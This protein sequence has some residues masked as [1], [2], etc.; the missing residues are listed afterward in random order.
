MSEAE[1][2]VDPTPG[3]R[4]SGEGVGRLS[5]V[6][7]LQGGRGDILKR[8]ADP[9]ASVIAAME[10]LKPSVS[11]ASALA[12]AEGFGAGITDTLS[13]MSQLNAGY[14]ANAVGVAARGTPSLTAATLAGSVQ[15]TILARVAMTHD[16]W[17]TSASTNAIWESA[18]SGAL[19]GKSWPAPRSRRKPVDFFG[20][21]EVEV[22]SVRQLLRA[23]SALQQ[24]NSGLGLVWRGQRNAAW[25]VDS[26][27]TRALRDA[28]YQLDE[29]RLIAVE[30]FQLTAADRW[31]IARPDGDLAFFA[32]LQH[33]GAPT[34][35][36]D[37]SLD[38]EIGVWFAVSPSRDKHDD[39]DGRLIA[40]GRSPAPRR[41]RPAIPQ[42]FLLP[43]GNEAFWHSWADPG[44]R[45]ENEW[46]TGR[47][48]PAWQPPALNR[49]MRAQR[50][51]FLFDSE[52][53]I[54]KD[55]LTMFEESL[56]E[57]WRA[58][59]IAQSTR[60][61]GIPSR[62]DLKAK[63]NPNEIVPMFS[64]R[65]AARAKPEILDYL[66]TKGLSENTIYPDKAGFVAY[67]RR[68]SAAESM[69]ED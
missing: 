31:G 14:L 67:L 18:L 35:L 65:I 20:S 13:V 61:L 30:K 10:A 52:P 25:A 34:R 26:S 49:R 36:I 4:A 57:S 46:G 58:K 7:G 45:R 68:V 33:Q 28:K 47:S 17:G 41:N 15:D 21:F 3:A 40:W 23:L 53:L 27:L 44:V 42:G 19:A 32:E 62:H 51:A 38:P 54:D 60:V 66:D 39:E 22:D 48:V 64:I 11:L 24:K 43:P 8:G 56:G 6:E 16:T 5:S 29:D 55:V 69:P 9:M 63:P 1:R 12:S 50:A 59:E 37:V 2:S